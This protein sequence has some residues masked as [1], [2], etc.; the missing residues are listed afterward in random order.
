MISGPNY[1][2]QRATCLSSG[3]VMTPCLSQDEFR[4]VSWDILCALGLP[5]PD[6]G[7]TDSLGH[8]KA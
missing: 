2:P 7:L 6:D 3:L 5:S 1:T 8:S 4:W